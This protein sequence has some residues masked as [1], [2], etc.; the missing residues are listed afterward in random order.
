M[1]SARPVGSPSTKGVSLKFPEAANKGTLQKGTP[2]EMSGRVS[3]VNSFKHP[4]NIHKPSF[5]LQADRKVLKGPSRKT[6]TLSIHESS[7]RW[8]GLLQRHIPVSRIFDPRFRFIISSEEKA[9]D[10]HRTGKKETTAE[11]R[12]PQGAR[13]GAS[14]RP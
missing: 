8:C 2:G 5:W 9:A 12:L 14:H 4:E 11:V 3:W 7:S 6:E 1:R 10:P 13:P